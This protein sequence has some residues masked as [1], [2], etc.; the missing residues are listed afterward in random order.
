M[1]TI[2]F[3]TGNIKKLQSAQEVLKRF[4]IKVLQEELETPEIQDKDI[5]KIAEFSAKFAAE[6]LDKPVIKVDVGFEINALNG[7][8]GPFSKYINEWL[9]P[10]KL[11]LLLN[12]EKNR[13][14]KFIDVVAYCEPDKNSISFVAETK[15]TIAKRMYGNNGWG[16]DKIFIPKGYNTTLASLPDKDRSKI[17]NTSHWY[18]LACHLSKG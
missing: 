17:W 7:F 6:K 18:K 4:S 8:P 11:L 9:V 1:K 15:G 13:K 3:I 12:G 2:T 5:K 14:A 16:I 10:D